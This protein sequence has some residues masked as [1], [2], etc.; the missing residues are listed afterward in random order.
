[1]QKIIMRVNRWIRIRLRLLAIYQ[2]L[3]YVPWHQSR[4]TGH[5]ILLLRVLFY[6]LIGSAAVLISYLQLT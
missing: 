1:M 3:G 2:E 4:K 5:L 6:L